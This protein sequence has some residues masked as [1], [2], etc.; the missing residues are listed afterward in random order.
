M[1]HFVSLV[2]V[3]RDRVHLDVA[4]CKRVVEFGIFVVATEVCLEE[5]DVVGGVAWVLLL[6][7]FL[8]LLLFPGL[9]AADLFREIACRIILHREQVLI[10]LVFLD[11]FQREFEAALRRVAAGA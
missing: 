10:K 8:V 4:A 2:A 9:Q 1:A 5:F 3:F 7:I 6:V 11:V